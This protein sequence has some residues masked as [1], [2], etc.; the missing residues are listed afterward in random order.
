MATATIK[1]TNT[2]NHGEVLETF[3]TVT[4]GRKKTEVSYCHNTLGFGEDEIFSALIAQYFAPT[5]EEPK[6]KRTTK[7]VLAEIAEREPNEQTI[8]RVKK[9]EERFGGMKAAEKSL[10]FEIPD[11]GEL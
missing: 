3:A 4:V 8:A 9:L 10:K 2:I 7:K 1:I 6:T 11:E 5:V